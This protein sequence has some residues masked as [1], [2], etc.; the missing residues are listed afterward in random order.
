MALASAEELDEVL[1]FVAAEANHE[2][3]R[4]RQKRLYAA[5]AML[6]DA[7]AEVEQEGR[8]GESHGGCSRGQSEVSPGPVRFGAP[9]CWPVAKHVTRL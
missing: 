8:T 6:H 5:F 9:S 1:G 7:V 3:N 2:P 4:R